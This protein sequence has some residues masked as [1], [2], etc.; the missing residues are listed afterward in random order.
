[1]KS[2]I[3]TIE[4]DMRMQYK[5]GVLKAVKNI[6]F[7]VDKERLTQALVDSRSFYNEGYNDAKNEYKREWIS[8]KDRLPEENEYPEQAYRILAS[9]SDGLVRNATIKSLLYKKG[10]INPSH[11][12]FTY[13][14]WMPLP[15]PYKDGG[16]DE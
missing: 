1:M 6:G 7:N 15:E 9:C 13:I 5:N 10:G 12:P 14:A 2:I 3:E 4:T 11:Q 8:V 16:L